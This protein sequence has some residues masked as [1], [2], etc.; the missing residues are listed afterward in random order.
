MWADG[1]VEP[2]VWNIQ[3]IDESTGLT[4]GSFLLIAHFADVTFGDLAVAPLSPEIPVADV[5]TY[6]S[7]FETALSVNTANGL[8]ANDLGGSGALTAVLD[9]DLDNTGSSLILNPDGSFDYTPAAGFSGLDTFTYFATDGQNNSA[10]VRVDINV[11]GPDAD[12]DLLVQLPLDDNQTPTIATDSGP[13]GNNGVISGASYVF[14]SGDGSPSSLDFEGGDLVN[15]GGLDVNG[16]GVTLAAWVKA[17]SFTGDNLDGQIITKAAGAAASRHIFTLGTTSRGTGS[18][19]VVL[20]GRVRIGGETITF[21]ANTGLMLPDVWYHTAMVY[22]EST[23]TLYLDGVEVASA[24]VTGTVDQDPGIDVTVGAQSNGIFPWDGLIDEVHVAR[25]GF[26]VAEI[27]ALANVRPVAVADGYSTDFET[28]LAVDSASGVLAND[29]D[30]NG[31]ALAANLVTNVNNGTLLLNTDGSFSYTPNANF[32]GTD[33]FTYFANDSTAES[34]AVQVTINVQAS[35]LACLL[36]T[37][38][39]PRDS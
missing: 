38:P 16:T 34:A 22:D 7:F 39:S 30:T 23:L 3:Y 12:P 27:A 14:E 11:L 15:L 35:A 25:R 10:P 19:D 2:S 1:N 36:Y 6:S 4:D 24:P 21:R 8:L 5:D 29:T 32:S 28:P 31:D 9:T 17:D 33:S 18:S 20:R 13:I 37:S 26:S